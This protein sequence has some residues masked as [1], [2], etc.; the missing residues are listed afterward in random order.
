M[1]VNFDKTSGKLKVTNDYA[2]WQTRREDYDI[3]QKGL[4]KIKTNR[5]EFGPNLVA[6]YNADEYNFT[7]LYSSDITGNSQI[8][9]ISNIT[10]EDFSEPQ[11]VTF[12]NS[13][14][15]D[16]YPT[17]NAE[18]SKIYFCSNRDGREI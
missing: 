8:N 13:E 2:N 12:L 18:K 16:M 5:N 15:E 4:F 9:F 10:N 14:F 3:I 7:L 17:F 1:N 6:E 11:E